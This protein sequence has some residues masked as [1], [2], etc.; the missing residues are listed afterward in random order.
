M[1]AETEGGLWTTTLGRACWI[2]RG[3]EQGVVNTKASKARAAYIH[4][5][6]AEQLSNVVRCNCSGSYVNW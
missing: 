1:R 6:F 3:I 2:L 4:Q 5:R